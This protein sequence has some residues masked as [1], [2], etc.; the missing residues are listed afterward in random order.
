MA[1]V[2]KLRIPERSY[3]GFAKLLAIDGEDLQQFERTLQ[4]TAPALD[5]AVFADSI[6]KGLNIDEN[7]ATEI[8]RVLVGLYSTRASGHVSISE[9]VDQV[10]ESLE[11]TGEEKLKPKDGNWEPFKSKLSRLLGYEQ[12]VGI[13]AKAVDI[14]TEHDHVFI[15]GE[16]RIVSDVRMIFSDSLADRPNAAVITHT[17]KIGYFKDDR[18]HQFF[19]TLDGN[20]LKDIRDALDR[21]EKKE[22]TL[23]EI[24]ESTG[25]RYLDPREE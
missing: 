6:A 11:A 25:I 4:E 15:S 19:V 5:P 24:L 20:D 23:R 13:T 2:R 17:L 1:Y 7:S 10:C 3:D 12:S 14:L 18:F 9:F 22:Q 21:A 8:M 16:C